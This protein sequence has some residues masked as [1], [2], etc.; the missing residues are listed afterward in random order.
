[1]VED[2]VLTAATLLLGKGWYKQ[3][4]SS[5][6]IKANVVNACL[7]CNFLAV[8]PLLKNIKESV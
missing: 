4:N 3:Y 8:V 6:Q 5:L 1:V 7:K 2:A